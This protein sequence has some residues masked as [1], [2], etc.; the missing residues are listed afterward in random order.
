MGEA[1]AAAL[2]DHF[3]DLDSLQEASEE[4]I[5]EVPDVGPVVAAHVHTF[6]RQT[7]NRE[8]IQALA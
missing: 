1:T 7:H 2:A 4:Q 6:F 8:V 5:Q 3:G